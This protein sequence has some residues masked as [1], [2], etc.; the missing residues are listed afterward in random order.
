VSAENDAPVNNEADEQWEMNI[1]GRQAFLAYERAGDHII[2][3][4]TEVPPEMEGHGVASTLAKAALDDA[5][6]RGQKV[7][8]LCPFVSNYIRRHPEYEELVDRSHARL[9]NGG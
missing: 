7:V 5:R 4:H 9:R 1:D 2:Y 8:P 3:L 6:A